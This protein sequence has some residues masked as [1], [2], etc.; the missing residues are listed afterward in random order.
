MARSAAPVVKVA[1]LVV[2]RGSQA[3]N[4]SAQVVKRGAEVV[5]NAELLMSGVS[6]NVSQCAQVA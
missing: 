1:A 2:L 4:P 6:V 5:Q 3:L